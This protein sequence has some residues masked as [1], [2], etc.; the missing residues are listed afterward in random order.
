MLDSHPQQKREN[1]IPYK[2]YQLIMTYRRA[3]C[4]E[5]GPHVLYY[6]P[7]GAEIM[8]TIYLTAMD[9]PVP[10]YAYDQGIVFSLSHPLFKYSTMIHEPTGLSTFFNLALQE[11]HH[12]GFAEIYLW[13]MVEELKLNEIIIDMLTSLHRESI[14]TYIEYELLDKYPSPLEYFLYMVDINSVVRHSIKA[15][16]DLFAIAQTRPEPM[17]PAYNDTY[18][19][20]GKLCY[21]RKGIYIVGGYMAMEI[22]EELGNKVLVRTIADG[23]GSFV[24]SYNSI[25]AEE[26]KIRYK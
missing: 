23:Y 9:E 16:N 12:F 1:Q 3:F 26:M 17:D 14:G 6:L 24:D 25:A 5:V 15:M 7:E 20:I 4:Q 13:P 19:W 22:K 11:L 10:A 21:R 8:V 2:L 18:R